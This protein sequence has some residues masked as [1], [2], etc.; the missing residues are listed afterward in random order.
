MDQGMIE[1]TID[2]LLDWLRFVDRELYEV[3]S[4]EAKAIR[5]I[6]EKH[7]DGNLW[8]PIDVVRA[9]VERVKARRYDLNNTGDIQPWAHAVDAELAAM[10][11]EAK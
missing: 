9:F 5:A 6:L 1:P 7:R 10:E 2:E 11:Q 8:F 4:F 3:G